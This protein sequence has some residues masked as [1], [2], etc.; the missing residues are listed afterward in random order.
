MTSLRTEKTGKIS[1]SQPYY[2][3]GETTRAVSIKN[4]DAQTWFDR[5]LV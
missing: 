5:G 1:A 4:K 2:D 3:M